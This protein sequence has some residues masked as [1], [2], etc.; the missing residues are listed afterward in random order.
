MPYKL[1]NRNVLVTGGTR[2]LGE[3]IC[4]KFAAEG[5]NIAINYVSRREKAQEMKEKMEREWGV[6]VFC[7]M[8]DMSQESDCIS[9]VKETIKEFGGLDI[10][11]S[12]AGYTRF[13]T[14]SDLSAPTPDDWQK[15]YA[16]NVVA[17]SILLR[18]AL[19][20]F[21][22]NDEGGVFIM[23]SSIAG[24]IAGGS[25]MPYSVTKAAQLHLMKCLAATQGPKVRVNA[26]LPGLILTEWGKT[27]SEEDQKKL[28]DK[29][30]LKRVTDI[31][32]C[33]QA[34]VDIAKNSS[35]TGQKIQVDSGLAHNV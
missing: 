25:C 5:C 20:T 3:V 27:Y 10:I 12:N 34:F 24:V 30:Y 31:E 7:L 15:C 8:G 28:K 23:T 1:H 17:Q 19:S 26:V 21:E 11:I 33:A 22:T 13:S 32:D 18:E 4:L 6:K 9:V 29:A 16:T 14:F 2:G 35:M